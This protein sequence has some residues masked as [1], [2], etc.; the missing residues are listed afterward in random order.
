MSQTTVSVQELKTRLDYYVQQ[1]KAG[2][3]LVVVERGKPIGRII[4]QNSPLETRLQ[5]LVQAGLIAWNGRK[6]APLTPVAR[7]R[8]DQMAADLLLEDRE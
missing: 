8:G 6:L 4:P 5:E 1:V 3:I 7:V 2:N